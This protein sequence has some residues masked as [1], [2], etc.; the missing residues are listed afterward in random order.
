MVKKRGRLKQWEQK[1]KIFG[2]DCSIF[3]I[4]SIRGVVTRATANESAPK[5][6]TKQNKSRL[7]LR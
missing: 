5:N 3:G 2:G 4:N 6:P 1:H 7:K